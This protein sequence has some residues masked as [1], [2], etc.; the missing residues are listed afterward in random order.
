MLFTDDRLLFFDTRHLEAMENVTLTL[1]PP[2]KCGP[3][4]TIEKEWE[5][6]VSR[7][8]CSGRV[9]AGMRR[10]GCRA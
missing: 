7:A 1:N 3:C 4:F 9:A 2:A 10:G 6:K 5:L 8:S